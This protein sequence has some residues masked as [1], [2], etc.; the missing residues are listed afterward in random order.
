MCVCV[1]KIHYTS[2]NNY[3]FTDIWIHAYK[4]MVS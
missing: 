3:F 4:G 1:C 2:I